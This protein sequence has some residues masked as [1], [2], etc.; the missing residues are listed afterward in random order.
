MV[1][2]RCARAFVALASLTIAQGV[3][4]QE[5]SGRPV[6]ILVGFPPG[7]APDLTARAIAPGLG[8][9]LGVSV[10]VD[11]RPGAGGQI[12]MNE[13]AR[14]PADGHTL[15]IASASQWAVQ[16]V[17]RPGSIDPEKQLSPLAVVATNSMYVAV[18]ATV[19]AK[20]AQEFIRLIKASPGTY[21]YG[22][23]G[24]GTVH[25]LFMES[26]MAA[27]GLNMQ[28]I[29]YKGTPQQ[30]QAVVAG[31]IPFVVVSATAVAPFVKTGQVRLLLAST[32]QRWRMNPD[33]PGTG[34]LGFTDINFPG[35][36]GLFGPAGMPRPLVDRLS[37]GI[38]KAV[39]RPELMQRADMMGAEPVYGTP[40]QLAEI[41]RGDL[42]RYAKAV[43]IA[44]VKAD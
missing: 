14:A 33:V 21:S 20:T 18:N 24:N 1:L 5:L 37:A 30:V 41:V 19:P 38:A 43:K 28:H 4:A 29:P 44:G 16:P 27:A 13:T 6:R 11:N 17:L 22:S 3:C 7:G 42:A 31:E 15:F 9:A 32:R 40:E 34:E 36:M 10:I 2:K 26:F 35:D 23:S 8:N 25:H 12:A 39:Q